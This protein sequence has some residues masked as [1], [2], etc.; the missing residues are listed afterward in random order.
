MSKLIYDYRLDE[1][2]DIYLLIQSADKKEARNGKPFLALELQ[3]TSGQIRAQIWDVDESEVERY[4]PGRVVRV[5]G[6]R[7]DFNGTPQLRLQRIRLAHEGE[8]T[9]PELYMQRA[10]KKKEELYDFLNSKIFEI[11]NV[12][13]NRIVRHILNQYNQEFFSASAAKVV[14]H[15]YVGG[16]SYHTVSMLHMAEAVTQYY[17]DIN[18]SL[19]YSGIILHDIGKIKEL[20][21]PLATE[22]TLAGQLQG[23]IVM[24]SEEISKACQALNIDENAEDVIVLKHVILAHHGKLEFGSPVEPQ[25]REA[26]I[27]HLIDVLDA[28]INILNENLAKTR[29][30]EYSQRIWAMDNRK[31]YKP[32]FKDIA[33]EKED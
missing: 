8:P 31:F 24:M 18:K 11:T 30:G 21:G 17:P 10:P 12:N 6:K 25:V 28:N 1:Y 14:H 16:L 19:L 26:E 13:M 15:A 29:P 22:Y 23:H 2:V 9:N 33:T 5:E 27:L 20:S 7:E 32:T 3:D 4:R